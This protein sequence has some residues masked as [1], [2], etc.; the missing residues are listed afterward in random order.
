MEKYRP[1]INLQGLKLCGWFFVG[2]W[3]GGGQRDKQTCK[4]THTHN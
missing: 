2:A 4:Q 1:T 3:Q